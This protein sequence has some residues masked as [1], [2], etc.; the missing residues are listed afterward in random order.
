[1]SSK[2]ISQ[3]TE[4]ETSEDDDVIA[5]VDNSA[6]ET[7]KQT[8]GNLFKEVYTKDEVDALITAIDVP[9]IDLSAQCNGVL[10][11]FDLGQ[12]VKVVICVKLNGTFVNYTL[13]AAKDEITLTF[14]PDAGEELFAICL[15]Y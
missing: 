2:K 12:T 15:V 1:M 6:G 8:K 4:L 10:T 5:I 14:P 11:A 3:L 7:K 9:E 13:N